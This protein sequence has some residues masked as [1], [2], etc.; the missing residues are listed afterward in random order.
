MESSEECCESGED[1]QRDKPKRSFLCHLPVERYQT[2][3]KLATGSFDVPKSQQTNAQKNAVRQFQRRKMDFAVVAGSLYFKGKRVATDREVSHVVKKTVN[4]NLGSGIRST[5]RQL[6]KNCAGVS[7]DT[8]KSVLGRSKQYQRHRPVFRNRVSPKHVVSNKVNDRWQLDLIDMKADQVSHDGKNQRYILSV[9]DTFSRFLFLRSLPRK[10]SKTVA[11]CLSRIFADQGQ[12]QV[13][14]CDQGT[15]FKGTVKKLL[16]DR[17]IKVLRSRPY[18]PQSQG[19]CER[20]HREV[21]NKIAFMAKRKRGYNWSRNLHQIQEAINDIPKEVLGNRAPS[22]VH[23]NRNNISECEEV[24]KASQRANEATTARFSRRQQT[25]VYHKGEK[26]LVKYPFQSGKVAPNRRYILNGVVEDRKLEKDMYKVNL[27]MPDGNNKVQW[28]FVSHITS[29]TAQKEKAAAK[30]NLT[31]EMKKD[32]HRQKYYIEVTHSDRVQKFGEAQITVLFDPR[33]SF[34]SCQFESVA[35]QLSLVG[36]HRSSQA[37]RHEAVQHIRQFQGMY[38][39]FIVGNPDEYINNMSKES[40]YGDHLSLL[41]LS[42]VYNVQFLIVSADGPEHT[43]FISPDGTWSKQMFLLSLGYFP[44]GNEEHYISVSVDKQ[45]KS[46][47]L[48]YCKCYVQYEEQGQHGEAVGGSLE[49]EEVGDSPEGEEG[50]DSPEG[51]E[52][53]HSPEDEE[54]SGNPEGEE[55]GGSPEGEEVGSSPEGEEVGD[56]PEDEEVS[57]NP[58]GDEVGGSPEGEEVGS[59]PE[60]EEVGDSPDL[61]EVDSSPKGKEVHGSRENE[62]V[63]D[64]HE[65]RVEAQGVEILP[66]ELQSMIIHYLLNISPASRYSLQRV[67]VFFRNIVAQVP[68]P[69]IHISRHVLS[70]V[71]EPVSVRRLVRSAGRGSGLALELRRILSNQRWYNAWLW[72][73]EQQHRNFEVLDISYKRPN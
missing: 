45:M 2:L 49:G 40:T 25:S 64:S 37:L 39:A 13:I 34:G 70:E 28:L 65:G 43:V 53:G 41:A 59:S 72:L 47:L 3:L 68:L 69:Q 4:K 38:I 66:R 30:R 1:L 67:N 57:G 15:E 61:E 35:H 60:G 56:S 36:I 8:V 62:E 7:H 5:W 48:S 18:H 6:G 51:E 32:C 31:A 9:I 46:E 10:D 14:Q 22:F 58:E 63:G 27:E 26:V 42:R 52:V 20:S 16:Q 29:I 23:R 55:V 73:S 19:K 12:P 54:V 17:G 24:R 50:G 21:R 33:Q 44:E 71:P 11:E